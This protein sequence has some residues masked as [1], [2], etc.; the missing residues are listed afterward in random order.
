MLSRTVGVWARL[1]PLAPR[2]KP[3]F[4]RWVRVLAIS[5][6]CGFG[7]AR[8]SAISEDEV[9][10]EESVAKLRECCGGSFGSGVLCYHDDSN[11]CSASRLPHISRDRSLCILQRSCAELRAGG[12]CD[13][14]TWKPMKNCGLC[15][16]GVYGPYTC[17]SEW[18]EPTCN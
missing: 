1:R 14:E 17:C 16:P 15:G 7:L 5:F 9:L 13:P 10:C 12:S 18:K 11:G 6:L 4:S 2:P 8:C 3:V